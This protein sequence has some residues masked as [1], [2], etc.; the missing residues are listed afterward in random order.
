MNVVTQ[1]PM[2]LDYDGDPRFQALFE[3]AALG[4]AICR[5]DGTILKANPALAKMMGCTVPEL[6]SAHARALNL[7]LRLEGVDPIASQNSSHGPLPNETWLHEL[8]LGKRDSFQIEK[9]YRRRDGSEFRAFLTLSLGRDARRQPAFLIAI[10]ANTAGS[11]HKEEFLREAEQ[12]QLIGR[13]AGG[14]AHDFNNLLTGILLCCDLLSSGLVTAGLVTEGSGSGRL[15]SAELTTPGPAEG[16]SLNATWERSGLRQHVDEVRLAGEHGAALTRQLLDIARKQVAD[17][18]PILVNEI[19]APTRNLLQ[20]LLGE[21]IELIV[22]LDPG[23]NSEAGRILADPA[24]LRQILFNLV[25]N[26]RDAMPEGGKIQMSTLSSE[27]P[28]PQFSDPIQPGNARPA[29]VLTVT[30]EGCGM[31]AATRA[32]LFELFFTTKKAGAGTGIGLATVQ[33]LV[34]EMGGRIEVESEL[35]RGTS[36]EVFLP[37]AGESASSARQASTEH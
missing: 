17:P 26:A 8:L 1:F 3:G 11:E 29:I 7:E 21:K 2:A 37:V 25:L 9:L 31:N 28:N 30:D 13:L 4:I 23:L 33:R 22:T 34:T 14:I 10:L 27:F 32:R 19:V 24:Q 12:M 20:R 6:M 18:R 35:G 16:A 15:G 36:I 5:F